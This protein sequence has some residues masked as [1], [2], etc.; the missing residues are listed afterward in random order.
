MRL[1][2][3]FLC[4]PVFKS[5]DSKIYKEYRY[6]HFAQNRSK[7]TNQLKFF[8]LFFNRKI[9]WRIQLKELSQNFTYLIDCSCHDCFALR[10]ISSKNHYAR[11]CGCHWNIYYRLNKQWLFIWILNLAWWTFSLL[12]FDRILLNKQLFFIIDWYF[13]LSMHF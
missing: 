9:N 2:D 7:G 6:S 3:S 8:T 12:F 11:K 4:N 13:F 5:Y 1:I 10:I